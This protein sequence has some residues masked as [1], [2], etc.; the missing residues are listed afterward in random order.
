MAAGDQSI[1]TDTNHYPKVVFLL[2]MLLI[3]QKED[4]LLMTST[5]DK[6]ECLRPGHRKVGCS[7]GCNQAACASA[8]VRCEV[9]DLVTEGAAH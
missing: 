2:N 7:A 8:C 1:H 9:T 3:L 6:R 4:L 5:D